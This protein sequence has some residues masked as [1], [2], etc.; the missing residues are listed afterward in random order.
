MATRFADPSRP[1]FG[2]VRRGL[3][4]GR[5]P[6]SAPLARTAPPRPLVMIADDEPGIRGALSEILSD[7]G[8]R[9]RSA[10][11]GEELLAMAR[12][13]RPGAVLL[14]L[15]MPNGDGVETAGALRATE[16]LEAVPII[17]V[18]SSW[19]GERLDLLE[20]SGFTASLR[21]PF[22][23]VEITDLLARTLPPRQ[24]RARPV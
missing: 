9:V 10:A 4:P 5:S 24:E 21:K 23:A 16:G 2:Q 17:A 19:L 14:D 7:A 13:E 20:P 8:Y 1:R 11:S 6:A 18:T 22:G 15:A 12:H 3:S